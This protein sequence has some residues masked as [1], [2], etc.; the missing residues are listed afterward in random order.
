MTVLFKSVC[1]LDFKKVTLFRS[2][3]TLLKRSLWD[4]KKLTYLKYHSVILKS[5]LCS[6]DL[7]PS[8]IPSKTRFEKIVD[9]LLQ[10][11]PLFI[12]KTRI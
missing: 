4:S 12:A 11:F 3:A 1:L 9:K 5:I 10:K 8:N 7:D 6:S 2:T